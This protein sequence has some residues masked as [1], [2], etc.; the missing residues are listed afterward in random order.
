MPH[1]YN[2]YFDKDY[3]PSSRDGVTELSPSITLHTLMEQVE[4]LCKIDVHEKK[5]KKKKEEMK[6]RRKPKSPT[7]LAIRKVLLNMV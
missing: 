4:I 3:L 7:L 2:F 5:K 6:K 1:Y